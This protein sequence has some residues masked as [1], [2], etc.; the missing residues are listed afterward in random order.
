ML[1]EYNKSAQLPRNL[2]HAA[3]RK[4]RCQIFRTYNIQN[5]HVARKLAVYVNGNVNSQ[6]VQNVNQ[7]VAGLQPHNLRGFYLSTLLWIF[8]CSLRIIIIIITRIYFE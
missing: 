5:Q 2:A 1:R 8:S 6:H 7:M 3:L 4:Q